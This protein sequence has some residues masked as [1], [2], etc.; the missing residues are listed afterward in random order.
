MKLLVKLYDKS[1]IWS[2]NKHAS[3]YLAVVSF[4]DASVFPISP[5]FM[6]APMFLAKPNKAIQY[7]FIA[8]VFSVAGGVLGYLLG[9]L[10]FNPI[11][12][13]IIKFMGYTQQFS[14]VAARFQQNE[15][16][17]TIVAG[18]MP[19]PYKFVAISAGLMQA[20][21]LP[22]I[23]ASIISRAIKF[24]FFAWL[25]KIG[26]PKMESK[27]RLGIEKF[28]LILIVLLSVVLCLKIFKVI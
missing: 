12:L 28:G 8:S 22:F 11:V 18:F 9:Y 20:S 4:V 17:T 10:V 13:P 23:A 27:I 24:F 6:L 25:I 2:H 7:A 1:L 19:I 14:D 16:W 3:K 26:G 21:L 5:Y 15:F